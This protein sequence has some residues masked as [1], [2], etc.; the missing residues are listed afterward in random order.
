M[1][2][3]KQGISLMMLFIMGSTLVLGTGAEA[4]KD[5]WLAIIIAVAFTCPMILVYARLLTLFPDK[6]I[7]EISE[8][9]LG[10]IFGKGVNLL[11]IWFSFHLGALVLRNF[12]EFINTVSLPE[13]PMIVSMTGL[14]LLCLWVIKHGVE[15]LGRWGEFGVI[16]L[17]MFILLAVGLLIPQMELKKIQPF[18]Q[19]GIKPVVKGATQIFAFPFAE[20]VVLTGIFGALKKEKS[21]Y[22]TYF[23][24]LFLGALVVFI[25]AFTEILVLGEGEYTTTFF[26][27]HSTVSRIN[28]RNFLQRLEIIPAIALLGGGFI[29]ISLCLLNACMGVAKTFECEDYRFVVLPVA[30]LMLNLAYW[31]YGSTIEMFEWAFTIWTYYAFLFQVILPLILLIAAEVKNRRKGVEENHG[32]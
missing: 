1:I 6:G 18:L 21:I 14:I 29:K 8:Q 24:G 20:T 30:L 9:V 11:Y 15:V 32:G 31:V 5:S 3:D 17:V 16:V 19:K 25:T 28:I 22:R 26:P 10:K 23:M 13:T 2:T 12:G 27:L 7:Y 4:G